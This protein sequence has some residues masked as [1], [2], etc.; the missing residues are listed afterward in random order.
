MHLSV[1]L[2]F[3]FSLHLSVRLSQ[4]PLRVVRSS[5]MFPVQQ[6]LP[7]AHASEWQATRLSV[8]AGAPGG[9]SHSYTGV[10]GIYYSHTSTR[11]IFFFFLVYYS[12]MLRQNSG[13]SFSI[14]VSQLDTSWAR[15]P[16]GSVEWSASQDCSI[17]WLPGGGPVPL[18]SPPWYGLS[19]IAW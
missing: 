8:S 6:L 10:T 15:G 12:C 2:S 14:F 16:A 19:A 5:P 9:Y 7:V 17:A 13:R 4:T 3:I 18:A 11:S 1:R